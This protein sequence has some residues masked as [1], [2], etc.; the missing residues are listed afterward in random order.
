MIQKKNVP[1]YLGYLSAGSSDYPLNVIKKAGVDMEKADY[2]NK[3][4]DV[5]EKRLNE[6]EAL[7]GK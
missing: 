1:L 4:F 2:L 5:F 6:F 3:A 7:A